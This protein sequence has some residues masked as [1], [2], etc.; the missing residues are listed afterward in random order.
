[1]SEEQEAPRK[2]KK[3][4]L[5]GATVWDIGKRVERE[6]ARLSNEERVMLVSALYG[7]YVPKP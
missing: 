1:M 5:S 7:K 6:L 4:P 3:K 2:T